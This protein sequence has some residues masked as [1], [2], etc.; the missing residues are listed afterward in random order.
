MRLHGVVLGNWA[1][2][3]PDGGAGPASLALRVCRAHF[4][5]RPDGPRRA[6]CIRCGKS[7]PS[8][9]ARPSSPENS[10]EHMWRNGAR[11]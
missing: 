4:V 11:Q 1:G 3:P 8:A 5:P 7:V 10:M 6:M 9:V 2:R